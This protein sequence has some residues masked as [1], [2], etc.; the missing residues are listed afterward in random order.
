[1]WHFENKRRLSFC[2]QTGYL[3]S[4][5][6]KP[7]WYQDNLLKIRITEIEISETETN[8]NKLNNANM[9]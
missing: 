9:G 2:R 7:F 3:N 5:P 6:L 1:M 4:K 8:K